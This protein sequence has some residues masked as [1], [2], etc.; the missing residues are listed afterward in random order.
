MA[1]MVMMY[2]LLLVAIVMQ[3]VRHALVDP[4]FIVLHAPLTCSY[5][6][7]PVILI[8]LTAFISKK[9]VVYVLL[10]ISLV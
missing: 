5:I 2:L 9:L 6:K 8:V 1:S 7:P 3:V 10:A 4:H